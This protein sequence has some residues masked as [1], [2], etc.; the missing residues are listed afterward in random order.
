MLIPALITLVYVLAVLAVTQSIGAGPYHWFLAVASGVFTL[1]YLKSSK[2]G[3]T[4][5]LVIVFL[6]SFA[7]PVAVLLLIGMPVYGSLSASAAMIL[8]SYRKFGQLSGLELLIPFLV[9]LVVAVTYKRSNI[10]V[11]RDAPQAARPLT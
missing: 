4:P 9:A 3:Y 5:P 11:K 2:G 10:A 8:E 1:L 7:F 6:V